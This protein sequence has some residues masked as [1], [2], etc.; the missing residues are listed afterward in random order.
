MTK[1]LEQ[2]LDE[3]SRMPEDQQDALARIILGEIASER[4]WP[5]ACTGS[6]ETLERLAD[7]ALEEFRRGETLPL[8]PESP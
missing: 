8:D 7:E 3:A 2:A 4:T 5:N 1:L 6:H